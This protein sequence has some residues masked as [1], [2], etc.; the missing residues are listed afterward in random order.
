M[1]QPPSRAGKLSDQ[2]A[3]D[4]VLPFQTA[5]PG[6]RGRLVRLGPAIDTILKRHAYPEKVSE[7]V[8]QAVALTAMLGASLRPGGKLS[9]QARTD[10]PVSF[11]FTDLE[12]DGLVRA[13]ASFD[14]ERV[15][16]VSKPG[17]GQVPGALLGS[18][19][20]ALTIEP[21]DGMDRTQGIVAF[22]GGS[23]TQAAAAYFRQSEQLPTYI[24]LAVAKHCVA[25]NPADG[26]EWH[27][28]SGGL[29]VQHLTQ[30]LDGENSSI[31]PG[32]GEDW[33]RIRLL[34]ASVEDHEMLDPCL[35]SDQLLHRLF[36]EES[37]RVFSPR[38]LAVHC[39]CS[40]ERV[41]AFLK[42]FGAEQLAG[43]NGA[44][45]KI[46]VKCEFCSTS[47]SFDPGTLE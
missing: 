41:E 46:A 14:A 31:A 6:V 5:D 38:P 3:G 27:W 1:V 22:D 43:M 45:G 21:G 18:G 10:G 29:I 13:T 8:A 44:D 35:S 47:Y 28:R 2:P 39:R 37:V 7:I 11:I 9:L 40:R 25:G 12:A 4:A 15:E 16:A 20:L 33:N 23:L 19:H 24:R 32:A 26:P 36:H 17:A 30:P 34:A 42:S